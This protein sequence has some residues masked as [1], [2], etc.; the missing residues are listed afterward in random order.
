M[1][2]VFPV[3]GIAHIHNATAPCIC[4]SVFWVQPTVRNDEN[5]KT[6]IEKEIFFMYIL[7][8]SEYDFRSKALK[9]RTWS[10]WAMSIGSGTAIRDRYRDPPLALVFHGFLGESRARHLPVCHIATTA[11]QD[12]MTGANSIVCR[13]RQFQHQC[14]LWRYCSTFKHKSIF[15]V[16]STVNRFHI[17]VLRWV[18]VY[19]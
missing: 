16:R 17:N 12:I 18:I 5:I 19:F 11:F 4:I 13:L 9:S 15:S 14:W 7:N 2:K 8:R 3:I 10:I 6:E 1:W